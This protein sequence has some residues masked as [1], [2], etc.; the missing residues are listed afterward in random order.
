MFAELADYVGM[1]ERFGVPV[2][3]LA[4]LSYFIASS[5]KWLG[6]NVIMTLQT[7]HIAFL[8]KIEERMAAMDSFHD[9]LKASQDQIV[10]S[11][12]EIIDHIADLEEFLGVIHSDDELKNEV[13]EENPRRR[14]KT[15]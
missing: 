13:E 5:V 4:A 8:D 12:E 1:V 11:Q 9:A 15:K 14:K 2:V 6:N 7:R 10:E 3:I